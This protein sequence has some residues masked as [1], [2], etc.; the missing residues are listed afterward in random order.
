MAY[1]RVIPKWPKIVRNLPL[2][3]C[4]SKTP[5]NLYLLQH[6]HEIRVD[7]FLFF[8]LSVAKPKHSANHEG[9]G[10]G[11]NFEALFHGEKVAE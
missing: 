11:A 7:T 4:S 2:N 8:T 9:R 6:G 1:N 3:T 10:R 5:N